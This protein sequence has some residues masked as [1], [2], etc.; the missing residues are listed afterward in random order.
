M[1]E[2]NNY[3][4]RLKL[5]E[6]IIRYTRSITETA[7]YSSL[8][9]TYF[10]WFFFL[11]TFL[12]G[13]FPYSN[14]LWISLILKYP[15]GT[16]AMAQ[17][18][19]TLVG[20]LEDSRSVSSTHVEQP[21]AAYNFSSQRSKALFWPPWHP[22]I[23]SI[24]RR[25]HTNK[26]ISKASTFQCFHL[27]SPANPFFSLVREKEKTR[28]MYGRSS[29]DLSFFC[30]PLLLNSSSLAS[31]PCFYRNI[32]HLS[33]VIASFQPHPTFPLSCVFLNIFTESS[34]TTDTHPLLCPTCSQI[35]T[36][37]LCCFLSFCKA[38]YGVSNLRNPSESYTREILFHCF[39][40][41]INIKGCGSWLGSRKSLTI[42]HFSCFLLTSL[43]SYGQQSARQYHFKRFFISS[44]RSY[45]LKKIKIV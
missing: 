9:Q 27:C 28:H 44:T 13:F 3:K 23:C 8:T 1:T 2:E 30:L 22:H 20:L 15:P 7:E 24:H 4:C 37:S 31:T 33:G 10:R 39:W 25:A 17:W 41:R 40:S 14:V 32:L 6:K 11:W 38:L 36:F 12:F 21:T 34:A 19:K 26:A 45:L 16:G 5:F 29:L 35:S 43:G 42:S 18:I